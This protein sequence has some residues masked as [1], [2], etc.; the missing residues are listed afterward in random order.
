M[1]VV[2][3]PTIATSGSTRPPVGRPSLPKYIDREVGTTP[4]WYHGSGN[5]VLVPPP[6]P[7][8]HERGA[9]GYGDHAP[10]VSTDLPVPQPVSNSRWLSL[11]TPR[12]VP[13]TAVTNGSSPGKSACRLPMVETSSP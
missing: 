5:T 3:S 4:C 13:P 6:P 7:Y 9:P 12:L 10:P 8:S 2:G 11:P 1:P